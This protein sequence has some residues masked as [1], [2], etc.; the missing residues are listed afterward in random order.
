MKQSDL[1]HLCKAATKLSIIDIKRD[2]GTEIKM[3]NVPTSLPAESGKNSINSGIT[4][5]SLTHHKITKLDNLAVLVQ[6]DSDPDGEFDELL[7]SEYLQQV[8]WSFNNSIETLNKE[9]TERVALSTSL[10]SRIHSSISSGYN[11]SGFITSTPQKEE[12]GEEEKSASKSAPP[13]RLNQS[14]AFAETRRRAFRE[15][16]GPAFKS[17]PS[18][19]A[20]PK[21]A[22]GRGR[23]RKSCT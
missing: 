17:L 6:E 19:A 9:F 22:R 5:S 13:N 1:G 10:G 7:D 4:S 16:S 23:G 15:K 2:T 3:T 21:S 12:P 18:G 20:T 11:D 8:N 14:T